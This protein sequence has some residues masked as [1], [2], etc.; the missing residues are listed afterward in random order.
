[1]MHCA[2]PLQEN[3]PEAVLFPLQNPCGK[4][5]TSGVLHEFRWR[6][7]TWELV[8]ITFRKIFL[9]VVQRSGPWEHF[10]KIFLKCFKRASP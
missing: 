6:N 3:F 1:M 2:K 8:F 10:R 7:G 4:F 9:K 5:A